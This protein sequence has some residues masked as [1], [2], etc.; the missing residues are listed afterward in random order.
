MPEF[1]TT[2]RG[3]EVYVELDSQG[4]VLDI[5]PVKSGDK[6][7]ITESDKV[8]FEVDYQKRILDVM[9]EHEREVAEYKKARGRDRMGEE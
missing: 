4:M 2:Y 8:A 9:E 3:R 7:V 5:Y 6:F 1:S